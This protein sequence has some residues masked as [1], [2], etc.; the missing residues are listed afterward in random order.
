MHLLLP[1]VDPRGPGIFFADTDLM[2]SL[3]IGTSDGTGSVALDANGMAHVSYSE[4]F[5]YSDSTL[6]EGFASFFFLPTGI[7][8]WNEN[9]E[10]DNPSF[11]EAVEV[12]LDVDGNNVYDFEDG[13][14]YVNGF[15]SPISSS[16]INVT[17]DGEIIITYQQAME[18]LLSDNPTQAQHFTHC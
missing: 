2:D 16:N 15:A 5:I 9:M 14:I 3:F 4:L 10:D 11:I 18:N 7:A 6:E 17:D 12:G 8:Y 1:H 13:A